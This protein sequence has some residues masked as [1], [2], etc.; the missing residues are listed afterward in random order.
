LAQVRKNE[1]S[2]QVDQ[3]PEPICLDEPDPIICPD[4]GQQFSGFQLHFCFFPRLLYFASFWPITFSTGNW[5]RLL[6]DYF[7]GF[8][9]IIL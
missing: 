8:K 9:E 7:Q 6:L 2:C 1:D 4:A 5:N 3:K